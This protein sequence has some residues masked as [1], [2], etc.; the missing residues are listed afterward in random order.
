MKK[1]LVEFVGTMLL[2]LI[3]CG[4][5]VFAG[6]EVGQLGIAF[7]FGLALVVIAYTFGS[8]SGA[9]VNPAVS[10]GMLIGGRMSVKDF[11]GYF[12]FQLLG[13]LLAAYI[14]KLIL[15]GKTA[16]Y[17][18]SF[19]GLG[20]NGWGE[21]YGY[22]YNIYSAAIFELI[23][24]F[25]F[26]RVIME[27]KRRENS[28]APL[29]IGFALLVFHLVGIQIT[30]VSLNPAR[31]FGPALLVGGEAVNQLW[32]FFAAPLTAGLLAGFAYRF[33]PCRCTDDN[34]EAPKIS[35]KTKK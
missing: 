24:T 17:D 25:I 14:L 23:A 13:A 33:C 32:L 7:A 26:I 16:G 3:G 27:N 8:I 10:F 22:G 31:S 4:T 11:L 6:A 34:C 20:Q 29:A 19:S 5:V 35:K 28:H 18:I 30:G 15:I 21:N 2:V 12:V 1:Y 9:H